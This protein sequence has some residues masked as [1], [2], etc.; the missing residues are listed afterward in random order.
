M[1][2]SKVVVTAEAVHALMAVTGAA[3]GR[4]ITLGPKETLLLFAVLVLAWPVVV[5][6]CVAAR[7]VHVAPRT[8]IFR[9]PRMTEATKGVLIAES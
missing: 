3:L 5:A 9:F 1:M 7:I 2:M 4:I 6:A 8:V